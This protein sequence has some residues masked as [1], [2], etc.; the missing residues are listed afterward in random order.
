M[1]RNAPEYLVRSPH[2]SFDDAVELIEKWHHRRRLQFAVTP[3]Y[4][5]T[6]SPEAL[7][8]A[9]R[10]FHQYDDLYL[11]THISENNKEIELVEKMYGNRRNYLDVYDHFG[12]LSERTFLGHGIHL[13][14]HELDRISETGTTIVHCPSSNLFLGS[15]L[16]NMQVM[17]EKKIA[18]AMGSD[19][20]AGTGFS[21]LQTLGDAYKVS[22]LRGNPLNALQA[23]YLIT[24]GAARALNLGNH[25]GNFDKGME[26]DFV[27]IEP[28]AN[29]LISY[30]IQETDNLGEILFAF[31]V[32]GDER[33]IKETYI[34]GKQM[35]ADD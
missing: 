28:N 26:A 23:F 35:Q 24:L 29:P 30:R 3:R 27:V 8:L 31:M 33:I 25:I 19:V 22:A 14:D 6:S 10:L 13:E 5:I 12:L 1:D 9:A 16:F 11:Q 32:L 21:M 17:E 7:E 20:G 15:G 2:A 18:V 4:A 34:M